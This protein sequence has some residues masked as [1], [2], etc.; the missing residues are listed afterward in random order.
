MSGVVDIEPRDLPR[1][2][3]REAAALTRAARLLA[4]WPIA[5]EAAIGELGSVRLARGGVLALPSEPAGEA[6]GDVVLGLRRAEGAGRLVV[7]GGLARRIVALAL[8]GDVPAVAP[9]ARLGLGERGVVA[10]VVASVLHACEAPFSVSLV[11]PPGIDLVAAGGVA[12]AL[13]VA[14]GAA[15]G[16][17][18]FEIPAG[19][20]PVRAAAGADLEALEVEARIEL[21]R[22]LLPA[23]ELGAVGPGDAIVFDGE[24]G[25]AS[26][27]DGGGGR[28]VV[29]TVGAHAARARVVEDG[30][31][32]LEGALRRAPTFTAPERLEVTMENRHEADAG[33]SP[34]P[35]IAE[36]TRR[37]DAAA[38]LAAAPIEIV[39]ELGR[40]VLRGEEVAGLGPGAVLTLGRVGASPVALRVGGEIWAEGELVDVEGELGVR[41][42]WARGEGR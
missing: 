17:A 24:P 39:A 4:R 34:A 29:V 30:T 19:W 23:A 1:V 2:S 21:A 41:V 25:L 32:V 15:R 38:V 36:D 20:L 5:L 14:L 26:A 6:G 8:G 22:T 11:A 18:R 27:F 12:I 7:D 31:V 42:T 9:V 13:D 28:A 33:A 40:L 3:A 35:R 37:I 16:W 10:G